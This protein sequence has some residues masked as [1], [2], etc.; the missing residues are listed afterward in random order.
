MSSASGDCPILVNPGILF[1]PPQMLPRRKYARERG[2]GSAVPLVL[3]LLG[4][5][6]CNQASVSLVVDPSV[7]CRMLGGCWVSSAARFSGRHGGRSARAFT[8]AALADLPRLD[9]TDIPGATCSATSAATRIR[10]D[11]CPGA[12]SRL[13]IAVEVV[14]AGATEVVEKGSAATLSPSPQEG[15]PVGDGDGT[16]GAAD[17]GRVIFFS[18]TRAVPAERPMRAVESIVMRVADTGGPVLIQGEPGRQGAGGPGRPLPVWPI[19]Q[20]L[21]AGQL[22]LAAGDLLES[23]SSASRV[24][25]PQTR[26][27]ASPAS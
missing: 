7:I 15:A 3:A 26:R 11:R 27:S 14:R 18:Q 4:Q 25:P 12:P 17:R 8:P 20:A 10:R 16:T 6:S 2:L 23:E 24:K 22:R 13:R 21:A 9:I 1:E 19:R 5:S